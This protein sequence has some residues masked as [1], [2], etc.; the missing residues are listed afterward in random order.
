MNALGTAERNKA[1]GDIRAGASPGLAIRVLVVDDHP[2]V[3]A[4]VRGLLMAQRDVASVTAVANARDA[5]AAARERVFDVA[6]VDYH[7]PDRDG[8]SLTRQLNSLP[9]PPGVLVYSAFADTRLA[10]AALVAGAGGICSKDRGD[11]DLWDAVR[12]V[13]AGV[14]VLPTIRPDA[15][16]AIARRIDEK[17]LSILAML[18]NRVAPADIAPTLGISRDWLE[19]RRWAILRQLTEP[20]HADRHAPHIELSSTASDTRKPVQPTRRSTAG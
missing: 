3:R 15:M 9:N 8:L 2:A 18:I 10:V 4:G 20:P 5:V 14:P 7:L 1:T 19:A 6:V 12:A 13:A 11:L 16:R 17:D